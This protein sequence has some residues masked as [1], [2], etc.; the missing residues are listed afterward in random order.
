[1]LKGMLHLEAYKR[2]T[3]CQV[4]A[5]Q[6]INMS[7][8]KPH[9]DT[10]PHAK[11]CYEI[12]THCEKETSHVN[13]T[14]SAALQRTSSKGSR[15]VQQDHTTRKSHSARTR[16][17]FDDGTMKQLRDLPKRLK[18]GGEDYQH[19]LRVDQ[20]TNQPV[21]KE[22]N[23]SQLCW[24]SNSSR[25]VKDCKY[26]KPKTR[27]AV[28]FMEEQSG[29]DEDQSLTRTHHHHHHLGRVTKAS[30]GGGSIIWAL[31]KDLTKSVLT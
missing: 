29:R 4:L 30:G 20:P 18:I 26:M 7:H 6:F 10:S 1:M 8:L 16:R 23:R 27:F 31:G 21:Q 22:P 13:K 9:R 25:R 12:M 28:R 2:M 14:R 19:R 15:S 17:K 3:P 11:S 5:H 24:T